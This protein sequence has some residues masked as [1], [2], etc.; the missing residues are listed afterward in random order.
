VS[1]Q[2]TARY[3]GR[4]ETIDLPEGWRLLGV[5]NPATT[6]LL[7]DVDAAVAR[8]L[9]R[10]VG[11]G[12]LREACAGVRRVTIAIDDQTRPTPAGQILPAL[13]LEL[14]SAGI[15]DEDVTILVAKGTHRWPSEEEVRAKA[16]PSVAACRVLV[17]DPDDESGLAFV[18]T[19]QR[20]TPI[21]VNRAVVE[22]DLFLAV[23]GVVTH[24]M[25]GYGGG[26]KIVLPGV[27]GRKTIVTNHLLAAGP[28]ALQARTTGNPMYEDM[29]EA[30]GLARLAMKI[31]AIL[32]MNNQLVEVVA[33][34]VGLGHQAAIA[35]YNRIYGYPVVEQAD[36]TITSGF[37]LESEL[38]QSCKA[39]LSA[40]LSTKDGG[41]I[42]LLSACTN[43][44]G[45]GFGEAISQQPPISEVWRWVR[46]GETTP[47]GGPMVARV[48][49][50]QQRKRV[51]LVTPNLA[52]AE[53]RRMGF[54]YAPTP[55][56]ALAALR[57]ERPGASVI[58]F[59]AGSAT[60]PMPAQVTA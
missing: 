31:D 54:D 59:P 15:E 30:A 44:I 11:M 27:S 22:A 23:G 6:T 10:P 48:L 56:A 5:G 60:N 34:S 57:A 4:D 46:T 50:V 35:A 39:V 26:P 47:T 58:V 41:A 51:V 28:N 1:L 3:C 45:P 20:G 2:V 16:G 8:A 55:K 38:L 52:E 17:H 7:S 49:G 25:A 24:Y 12:S 21:W 40:D 14:R 29:L 13:L 43:G 42:V 37:P 32:D 9:A 36:V 33:G 19:T 18:G 53:V